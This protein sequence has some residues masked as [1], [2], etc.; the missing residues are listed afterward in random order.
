M[1]SGEQRNVAEDDLVSYLRES[2]A[3]K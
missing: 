3:E 2:R 1:N